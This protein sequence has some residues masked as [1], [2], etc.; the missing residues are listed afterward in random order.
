MEDSTL[1]D[2]LGKGDYQITLLTIYRIC[3][4][5]NIS[6]SEFFIEV[7]KMLSQGKA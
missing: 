5:E 7:E 3:E 4:G 2:I 6:P 1:R